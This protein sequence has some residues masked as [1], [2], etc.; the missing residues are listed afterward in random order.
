V[1]INMQFF[2]RFPIVPAVALGALLLG[3]GLVLTRGSTN[4]AGKPAAL[5]EKPVPVVATQVIERNIPIYRSGLGFVEAYNKVSI[6][7]R[8]EGQLISVF[9]KEGQEVKH[10]DVLA[11]IDP[12]PFEAALRSKEAILRAIKAKALAAKANLDRMNELLQREV[13]T[14]Q[15]LDNQQALYS[16]LEAQIDGAE[17]EVQTAELHYEYTAVRSPIA[18]RV[19]L[20][21]VDQ[22]NLVRPGDPVIAVVTQVQPISI[23]FSLPQEDLAI[24][25][26]QLNA[27]R[28]MTVMAVARDSKLDLGSGSLTTIDNQVDSR[29][30]TFKL[31]ATFANEKKNLW[32][33]EFVSVKLLVEDSR[34]ALVVPASAIQRGPDGAYVYVIDALYKAVMRPVSVDLMQDGYAAV[35]SGLNVGESIVVEGQ[36]KL[37]PGSAVELREGARPS[38]ATANSPEQPRG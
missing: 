29:T 1:V 5:A 6:T 25:N 13:G 35:R 27:G 20:K 19:G 16:E 12:R 2:A 7:A 37:R 8:V 31:K 22:G 11:L 30:G 36:F 15:A 3:V 10:L 9:F 34:T 28:T 18:G 38:P 23:V 14:R 26:R 24:V 17:A 4:S 21:Q 33:G 32:P